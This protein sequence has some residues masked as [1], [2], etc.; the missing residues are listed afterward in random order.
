MLELNGIVKRIE[1]TET[2]NLDLITFEIKD[3]NTTMT[4]EL[5]TRINPFNEEDPVTIIMDPK[6]I[7]KDN[8]K[9]ALNG[10]LYSIS[11]GPEKNK[12]HI[13]VGGLQFLVETAE[14]YEDLKTKKDL[15]ISF[16]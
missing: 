16:F 1:K 3:S 14:I 13:S 9:L 6:P 4:L 12:I 7:K 8:P 15:F 5:T 10:F 11:K 2:T